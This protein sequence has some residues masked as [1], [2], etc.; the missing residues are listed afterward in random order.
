[1]IM[2]H[3]EGLENLHIVGGAGEYYWSVS[4]WDGGKSLWW[5][6]DQINGNLYES[7]KSTGARVRCA[8]D[9]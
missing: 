8:R 3:I 4:E 9:L 7:S 6:L 1:M 2:A 5:Y